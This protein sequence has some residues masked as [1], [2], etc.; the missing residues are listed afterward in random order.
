MPFY[1]ARTHDLFGV[2]IDGVTALDCWGLGFAGFRGLQLAPGPYKRMGFTA[3][4]A[5][6]PDTPPYTFHFPDGNASIARMLV[7]K[8]VPDAVSGHTADDVV[9]AT[10]DYDA[11]D[12]DGA[13]VRIRLSSTVIAVEHAG[14]PETASTVDVTYRLAGT[15]YGVQARG[16]VMAGWNMMIPYVV[17]TLPAAQKEALHYGVKVPLVYTKVVL[18]NWHA[19]ERLGV[20]SIEAPGMY[21]VS[22]DLDAPIDIGAYAATRSPDEP[23]VLRMLHTPC[24]PG[25]SE[26]DQHRVGRAELLQTPYATFERT[27]REQLTRILG[28]AGFDA[29]R[30][31]AAITVN[32]WPHGYAY[33]YNPLWDPDSFFDGGVTPNMV[34]R[35]PFG[36]ITIANSDAAAAAYTDKAIDQ[37]YRAVGELPAT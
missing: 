5:A 36:R 9:C 30:D 33:E 25:L 24:K 23:I 22:I 13:Q 37:A 15:T 21:H 10:T 6:V 14:S 28:P 12:R 32:R 8:L 1:Q 31:I 19:F 29:D 3:M 20:H 18:R 16:V 4:G 27:I 2:G 35:K 34:A 26:R 17:P 11:L 7:R